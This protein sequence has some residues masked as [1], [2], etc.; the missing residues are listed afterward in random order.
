MWMVF[1]HPGL[2]HEAKCQGGLRQNAEHAML[3]LL[4]VAQRF[5]PI[6]ALTTRYKIGSLMNILFNH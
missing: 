6:Y 3:L 5:S 4:D 2:K 1:L